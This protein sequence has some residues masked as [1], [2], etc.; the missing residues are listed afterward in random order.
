MYLCPFVICDIE[1]PHFTVRPQNAV[2]HVG[3]DVS[4]DCRATG[5]PEPVVVRLI[6]ATGRGYPAV[7]EGRLGYDPDGGVVIKNVSLVDAGQYYCNASNAIG[8]AITSFHITVR[9]KL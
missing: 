5:Y 4:I 2:V 3:S 7:A 6:S 8:S 9:R 1:F